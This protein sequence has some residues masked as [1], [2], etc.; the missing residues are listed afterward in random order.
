MAVIASK[1]QDIKVTLVDID[2]KRI[3]AWN[4]PN[5]DNLPT[6]EPGLKN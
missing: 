5:L 4:D 1:C 3:N 6:Y 2:K